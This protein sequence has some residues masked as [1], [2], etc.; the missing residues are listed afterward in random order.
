MFR[1]RRL[2][3]DRLILHAIHEAYRNILPPTVFPRHYFFWKCHIDE[4]DVNVHPAKMKCVFAAHSLIHDFT[5]DTIR[6]ALNERKNL[7]EF[8]QLLPEVRKRT[9][10]FIFFQSPSD[11]QKAI[12][13]IL[14][15]RRASRDHPGDGKKSGGRSGVGSD[16]GFDLSNAPLR[17]VEQ[18]FSLLP[19]HPS[20]FDRACSRPPSALGPPS[21]CSNADAPA[22]LPRL[23]RFAI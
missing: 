14:A 19:A 23:T 1:D 3:L 22:T 12:L 6:Q 15:T 7:S 21:C 13:Q 9:A 20:L 17:P 16:G 2:V 11:L 8:W 5:R 18:R 10:K 4:V